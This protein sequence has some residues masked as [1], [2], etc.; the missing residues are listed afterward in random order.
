MI[1]AVAAQQQ[2][3]AG[4]QYEIFFDRDVY[5]Y[6][7]VHLL[8]KARPRVKYMTPSFP[9]PSCLIPKYLEIV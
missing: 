5:H 6:H 8:E 2:Y 4:Q 7:L 9:P 3:F 1:S